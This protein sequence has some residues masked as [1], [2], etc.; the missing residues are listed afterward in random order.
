MRN[1]Y[2]VWVL[3]G[4]RLILHWKNILNL[5][6]WRTLSNQSNSIIIPW[7]CTL[8]IL[9]LLSRRYKVLSLLYPQN[10]SHCQCSRYICKRHSGRWHC[11]G[12]D[13]KRP[14]MRLPWEK[15]PLKRE[16]YQKS[17]IQFECNHANK[18]IYGTIILSIWW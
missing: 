2:F 9:L 11:P 4:S 12:R 13:H 17:S 14:D 5:K 16:P 18:T 8:H 15:K 6:F 7:L 10:G 1:N 3:F